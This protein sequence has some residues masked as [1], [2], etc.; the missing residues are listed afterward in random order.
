MALLPAVVVVALAGCIG[1]PAEP[2]ASTGDGRPSGAGVSRLERDVQSTFDNDYER[3][4][5]AVIDDGEVVTVF[6]DADEDTVFEIGS[7]TKVLTGELLAIAVERGEVGLDDPLGRFLPLGDAPVASVTLRSLATHS[8]GLPWDPTDP[9][10]V[11]DAEALADHQDP[12]DTTLEELLDLAR[13]EPLAPAPEPA[14]SNFGAALLGHALAA[15]AGTDYASLLTERVLRPIGMDDAT[16]VET[17]DQVPEEHAGGFTSAGEP[18]EPFSIGAFSPAGGVHATLGDVVALAQAVLDGSLS[19]SP[20]LEPIAPA[21]NNSMQFGYFWFVIDE[22][23][24][25]L[26]AHDGLT[27]GFGASLLIDRDAE[28]A[29]IVLVNASRVVGRFALRYLV[30][31]DHGD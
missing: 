20:A 11:A 29:S 4:A 13:N 10:W 21:F 31:S 2:L 24:R 26:T 3:A 18:V 27:G 7:I 9:E 25:T 23:P 17:P 30:D 1:P 19:D 28:Q 6:A 8:S 12:F 16:V 15:A 14:Y 22:R 5:V